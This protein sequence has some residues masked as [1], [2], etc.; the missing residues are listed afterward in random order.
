MELGKITASFDRFQ[1][2][3]E[4]FEGRLGGHITAG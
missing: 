3:L 4:V 1:Q 2:C